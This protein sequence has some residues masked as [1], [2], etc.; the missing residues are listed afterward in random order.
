MF[1]LLE[2]RQVDR[3]CHGYISPN[4]YLIVSVVLGSAYNSFAVCSALCV[5]MF[6]YFVEQ[7]TVFKITK[8]GTAISRV[9]WDSHLKMI[10]TVKMQ[11]A[12]IT[13]SNICR[14]LEVHFIFLA[15]NFTVLRCYTRVFQRL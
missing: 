14:R 8:R 2:N 1:F 11:I 4:L 10:L 7:F 6:C 3:T 15:N 5:T 12:E 13:R 9:G